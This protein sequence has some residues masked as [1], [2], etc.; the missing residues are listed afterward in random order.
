MSNIVQLKK[1]KNNHLNMVEDLI[2]HGNTQRKVAKK[3]GVSEAWLSRLRQT[4]LFKEEE[5][6]L[7][8]LKRTE[9]IT[10]LNA[11]V[12]AAVAALEEVVSPSFER[13]D[14]TVVENDKKVRVK[15]AKEILNRAGDKTC[16]LFTTP[17]PR[18][19]HESRMTAF[20]WKKKVEIQ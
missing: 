18:E 13:E 14:G 4:A 10:K 20:G 5:S 1:L 3:H 19:G 11:I 7:R 8:Q 12:L 2:L 6:A 17:S 16:L 15:A 9:N